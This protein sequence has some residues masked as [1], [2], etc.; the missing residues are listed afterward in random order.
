MGNVRASDMYLFETAYW[1]ILK[2]NGNPIS[3][4]G[5]VGGPKSLSVLSVACPLLVCLV[6]CF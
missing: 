5:I 6:P 2:V 3:S 1:V 4:E